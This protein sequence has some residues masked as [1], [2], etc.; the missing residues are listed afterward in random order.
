MNCQEANRLSIISFLSSLGFE[1][2]KISGNNYWYFSPI[3]DEKS[4]S[5]KVDGSLN[6][7]YDHG[8]G[9][10]GK[11]VDLGIIVLNVTVCEFLKRMEQTGES[12]SFPK[13]EPRPIEQPIIRKVKML[14]NKALIDYLESRSIP[15]AIAKHFCL[16]VYF[17][18]KGKNYFAVAFK[19]NSNGIEVRNRFFKGSLGKKDITTIIGSTNKIVLFEGF[20]DFL[21]AQKHLSAQMTQSSYI[22]LNSVNQ[23]G[24]AIRE[25]RKFKSP[26]IEVFFDNDKA[27]R[28]CLKTLSIE[29]PKVID[30]SGLY[31]DA[32]DFNEFIVQYQS[33]PSKINLTF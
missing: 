15:A 26:L 19:N 6:R 30:G 31:S 14:E 23:I 25:I 27:G 7:W 20:M 29:F 24:A 10:G 12:F 16:E 8:I 32:K 5:F 3:R 1:P 2:K 13:H 33:K 18:V 11:L 22:I 17:M 28:D 4:A 9:K 21:S